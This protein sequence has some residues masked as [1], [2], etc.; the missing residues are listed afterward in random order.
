M[1][2]VGVFRY[3]GAIKFPNFSLTYELKNLIGEFTNLIAHS[4]AG[5]PRPVNYGGLILD[6]S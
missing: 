3:L 4:Y 2:S 5:I 6:P 1:N